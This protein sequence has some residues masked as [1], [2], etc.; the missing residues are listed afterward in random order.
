[1]FIVLSIMLLKSFILVSLSRNINII[2]KNNTN[3]Q[4]LQNLQNP[5][6]LY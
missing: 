6:L 4:H 1:M 5:I 2:L 3:S